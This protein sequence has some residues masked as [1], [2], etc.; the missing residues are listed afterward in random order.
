MFR[1]LPIKITKSSR[2]SLFHL[3][4][5]LLLSSDNSMMMTM[6]GEPQTLLYVHELET[7]DAFNQLPQLEKTRYKLK[8]TDT[9]SL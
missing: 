2:S 7:V 3:P 9:S 1:Y 5:R 8:T 4:I 6:F